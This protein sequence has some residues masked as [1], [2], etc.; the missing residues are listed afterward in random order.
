MERLGHYR[1]LAQL[2]H[3][4]DA[5]DDGNGDAH[6]ARFLYELEVFLVVVEQLCHRILRS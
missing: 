5:R 2:R 1:Q 3:R 6:L 4:L